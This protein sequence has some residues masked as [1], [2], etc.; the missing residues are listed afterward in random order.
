[1][2]APTE[3]IALPL[4]LLIGRLEAAGFR[5]DTSR[6]LRMLRVFDDLGNPFVG[7]HFEELKYLL[8][9]LVSRSP[10]E[11]ERFYEV[12]EAFWKECEVEAQQPDAVQHIAEDKKM[13]ESQPTFVKSKSKW[14]KWLWGLVVL[15][16][17]TL[18][19]LFETGEVNEWWG[20]FTERR[21]IF[22]AEGDTLQMQAQKDNFSLTDWEIIDADTRFVIFRDTGDLTWV[23]VK[24]YGGDILV[25]RKEFTFDSTQTPPDTNRIKIHCSNPPEVSEI[26]SSEPPPYLPD[27][28]YQF[29][30]KTEPGCFVE[31]DSN[32]SEKPDTLKTNKAGISTFRLKLG[33]S[34]TQTTVRATVHR[35]E[36]VGYCYT[37]RELPIT[38]DNNKPI[39]QLAEFQRGDTFSVF[40]ISRLGWLLIALPLL[41]ALW[42]FWRWRKKRNT[43]APQK[44]PEELAAEYPIVDAGPYFI[45]YLP[46][47]HNITV[48]R[49]FFRIAEL[50]RRREEG[51]RRYFDGPATV[52]ATIESGGFPAWRERAVTRPAEYLFLVERPDERNQQG[53]LFAR[54]C[55][56]LKRRDVPLVA[57]FHD[58]SFSHF[59][60]SE[61]VNGLPPAELRR[62]YP[63]HRLVLLGAAHGLV[64]P[65][66][67]RQPELLREP[68]DWLTHWPR[69]L[70]LS[71]EPVA[72]W[73][74]QE[75]LLHRHFLIFPADT[76]GVLSGIDLLDRTEEYQAGRFERWQDTQAPR[77]SAET[78]RYR[79]WKTAAD[80]ADYLRHDPDCYRWLCALAVCA[81][82]DWSLTLAIG[83]AVG[84]EVT[85]DRLLLLTRIPWLSSN[86]PNDHLRLELLRQ[87]PPDDEL[88]ARA[89]VAHELE[90]VRSMTAG[91]FAD[92]ERTTNA[93]VQNFALDPRNEAHKQAIRELRT[94]GLLSGSQDA[95]LDFIVQEK[96]D[97]SGLPNSAGAGIE[98]WLDAPAPK[99]FWTRD[100]YI[101]LLSVLLSFVLM[102][103]LFVVAAQQEKPLSTPFDSLTEN[104]VQN[105]EL[106]QLNE[107]AIAIA[108]RVL[109]VEDYETWRSMQ[110]E[111][112][113]ADSL[114]Q[115]VANE[116]II[117]V[118]GGLTKLAQ[119]E[120]NLGINLPIFRYNLATKNF[121]F[122]QTKSLPA[123]TLRKPLRG[124]EWAANETGKTINAGDDTLSVLRR[125]LKVDAQHGQGLCYY[126]LAK[127]SPD[128]KALLDS[129]KLVYG[130]ISNNVLVPNYFDNIREQMP[131]NLETLLQA[132]NVVEKSDTA[133]TNEEIRRKIVGYWLE[134]SEGSKRLFIF[135]KDETARMEF[136]GRIFEGPWSIEAKTLHFSSEGPSATFTTS[137]TILRL[138]DQH[139]DMGKAKFDH[140][141]YRRIQPTDR[142]RDGVLDVV[143][144]CPNE[145]GIPE[146]AGCPEGE[147]PAEEY[148]GPSVIPSAV[149][150]QT[151]ELLKNVTYQY[152]DI[153]EEGNWIEIGLTEGPDARQFPLSRA[154]VWIVASKEGFIPDTAEI[155]TASGQINPVF[156]KTFSLRPISLGEP[157][158]PPPI[159]YF[160]NDQP[161][162]NTNATTT[163][164]AYQ[165]LYV[166][167]YRQKAE[168]VKKYT[169]GLAKGDNIGEATAQMENFFEREVR[170]GWEQLLMF[171]EATNERLKRGEKVELILLSYTAPKGAADYNLNLSKRRIAS[172]INHFLTFDGGA[173]KKFVDSGQLT[174]KQEP[175]GES[176]ALKGISDDEKDL[177]RSVYNLEAMKENRVVIVQPNL[178]FSEH[179]VRQGETLSAIANT[180]SVDLDSLA[181]LN[182]ISKDEKLIP[183]KRLVVPKN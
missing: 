119:R 92:T 69:R 137:F 87:L 112:Q 150:Y 101:G 17:V 40:V 141:T 156:R 142:D 159:L 10:Q 80:H 122:Y 95:E 169:E 20:H 168:Y 70:L 107:R 99:K 34:G 157:Y 163:K 72:A 144:N 35:P 143:D 97:K 52:R 68:L 138:N 7:G 9:P 118:S 41:P 39:L 5:V 45:P 60:N 12:F 139:L 81:Q 46:Q 102:I 73:S 152:F 121:N 160:D 181:K 14:R 42:F 148:T 170:G 158:I 133:D 71:P 94:L 120:N 33:E 134:E 76:E 54:L 108:E 164:Q 180:Y 19:L 177:F 174:F 171:T 43:P 93:A 64:N 182:N 48:P 147:V 135:R 51:Q 44:T 21:L 15:A 103:A 62:R 167:Y 165:P 151:K 22:I 77:H 154:R 78:H 114:F 59:W 123:D 176:R 105:N 128:P 18:L 145:K 29:S 161:D 2:P 13:P 74:F 136:G 132:E 104:V 16:G 109:A 140:S 24:K 90:A 115:L 130:M 111:V 96:A 86:Q 37:E 153:S 31:W 57:F 30:I 50:L 55:D 11:Q 28:E 91:S 98:G 3:H 155:N 83:R 146:K 117:S 47:E 53:K 129:A 49:E 162:P 178:K 32:E 1:M 6:R 66:A 56:F 36:K 183:G 85:H 127:Q 113:A 67:T 125:N 8:S 38:I 179:I 23:V 126:Y 58:G 63:H 131:V 149:N 88:A 26:T 4:D 110:V 172:V 173:Y 100:M 89:A 61:Y 84:V 106:I 82:P 65:Y 75:A 124:F 116:Q 27:K 166:A 175:Y 25:V 79:T